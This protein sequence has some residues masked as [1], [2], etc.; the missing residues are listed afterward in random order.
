MG[1]LLHGAYIMAIDCPEED[2]APCEIRRCSYKAR[3]AVHTRRGIR[4]KVYC[5]G[6]SRAAQRFRRRLDKGTIFGA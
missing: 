3:I 5:D 6:H 4:V 1:D 2:R